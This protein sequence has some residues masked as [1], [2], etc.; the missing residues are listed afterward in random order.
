MMSGKDQDRDL[1]YFLGFYFLEVTL[2]SGKRLLVLFTQRHERR[3]VLMIGV[4]PDRCCLL[5]TWLV[6]E[7]M[8]KCISLVRSLHPCSEQVEVRRSNS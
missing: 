6:R 4:E 8:K 7:V 2:S 3:V 5:D 1:G